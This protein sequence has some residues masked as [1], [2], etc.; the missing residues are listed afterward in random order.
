M[1]RVWLPSVLSARPQSPLWLPAQLSTHVDADTRI[2][3]H[4]H[5][6]TQ[7]QKHGSHFQFQHTQHLFASS[8]SSTFQPITA[9]LVWEGGGTARTRLDIDDITTQFAFLFFSFHVFHFSGLKLLRFKCED[10]LSSVAPLR[11]VRGQTGM[12]TNMVVNSHTLKQ[13]FRN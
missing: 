13:M 1:E 12:W 8:S 10:V 5:T 7:A 4:T 6:H 2:H 9:V 3:T 11:R